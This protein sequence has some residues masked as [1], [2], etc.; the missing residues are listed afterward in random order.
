MAKIANI[1]HCAPTTIQR[2]MRRYQIKS[3]TL[4]GAAEVI[5][6]PKQMLKKLYYQNGLSTGQI[7]RLYHCSHATI[8]N[9]MKFYG[10]KR[11]SKLGLRR[12]VLITKRTLRNLYVKQKFSQ[13]KIAK[14]I[15]CSIWAIQKLMKKYRINSRTLSES[16]MKY[17]KHNFSGDLIEKA[18]LIG[19][20]LGDLRVVPARLQI[21][22]QCSTTVPAQ[23][24]LIKSLFSQYTHLDIKKR[25]FIKNQLVTDIRCLLNKSFKF[26]LPKEDRIEPW[27]LNRGKLFF[28]FL[29]G[30]IDAEGY[31]FTRLYKKSKAPIAGFQVQSYDKNILHQIWLQLK[32][33]GIKCPKPLLV[34]PKGYESKL[35]FKNKK[36]M[37]RFS[38]NRKDALFE[39]LIS[40]KPC[41]KHAKRRQNLRKAL[42]NLR[43]RLKGRKICF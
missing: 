15:K 35:G 36:D 4:S 1:F 3:R 12:P 33:L 30:Y 6:I 43:L 37:W 11:R 20:R 22:V 5:V 28:A 2:T 25:R 31:I 40:I 29:S 41:I 21:Q 7:G 16:Q 14:K 13:A 19:F 39:L 26:L 18:Y 32:K 17:P 9:K 23:V 24:Q 34:V 38:V 8:L 42:E 10:L 27:I